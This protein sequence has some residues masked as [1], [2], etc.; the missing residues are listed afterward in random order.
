MQR[1]LAVW[2]AIASIIGG[3][4]AAMGQGRG[5]GQGRGS[6]TQPVVTNA[7]IQIGFGQDERRIIVDWFSDSRNLKG[8]PPGLAKREHLPPGLQRQ[9]VKN[10]HLPPGLEKKIEPFPPA[11]EARLPRLPEG[12]QRVIIGGN[13]VLTDKSK[14]IIDIF[15]AF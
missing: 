12:R 9:M 3:V 15:V 2:I 11:L 10:G 6:E 13:I 14:S 8:L 1:K 7:V 5:R 4:P